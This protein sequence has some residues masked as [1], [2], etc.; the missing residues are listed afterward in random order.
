MFKGLLTASFP[1]LRGLHKQWGCSF[2]PRLG[3]TT[4]TSRDQLAPWEAAR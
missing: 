4:M 3:S 2:T 1:S